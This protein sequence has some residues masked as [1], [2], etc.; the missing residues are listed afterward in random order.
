MSWKRKKNISKFNHSRYVA[1]N[2]SDHSPFN[3]ICC[4][5]QQQVYGMLFRNINKLKKRLVEVWS[6]T[7]STLLSANGECISLPVF[8]QM[9]YKN[10]ESFEEQDT[11]FCHRTLKGFFSTFVNCGQ[12]ITQFF[13]IRRSDTYVTSK[14]PSLNNA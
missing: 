9:A 7:L 13:H 4:V 1:L 10:Y 5:M 6:R 3:S 12:N 2:S 11:T 14:W 8:A